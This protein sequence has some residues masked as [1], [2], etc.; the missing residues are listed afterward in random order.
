MGRLKNIGNCIGFFLII[1]IAFTGL[2]GCDS[3]K[4]TEE[5]GVRATLPK[6]GDMAPP[7]KIKTFDGGDFDLESF[8]GVKPVVINFWAS[9]CGPCRA[10]APGLGKVHEAFKDAVQFVAVAVQDSE[11]GASKFV[12]EYKWH[13]PVGM[14]MTGE[15]A[16]RFKL[17]GLPKTFIVGKDGKFTFM[18]TGAISEQELAKEIEKVL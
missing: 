5:E 11:E 3:K 8:K 9:W 16:E 14:D 17:Y 7:L 13:F 2:T 6:V 12:A 15:I 4:A 10:E 1:A 18:Y